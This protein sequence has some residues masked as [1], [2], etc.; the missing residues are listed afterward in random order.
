LNPLRFLCRRIAALALAALTG[1]AGSAAAQDIE[2][3]AYS[4]API[5]Y[6]FLVAGYAYTR[7]GIAFNPS[8][9]L[10]NPDLHTSNAVLG[11][12]RVIELG[13]QSAKFDFNVPYTALSGTADYRG[14][15]VSR[16]I[17]GF[18]NPAFRLSANLYGAP[19]LSPQEFAGWQQDVIVGASLRVSPPWSQYDETRL[20]NVGTNRWTFKPELGVSKAAGPW[21]LELAG[22]AMFFTDNKDFF[23]GNSLSQKPLYSMQ[24]HLIYGFRNGMWASIDGTYFAGGRTT[25][26]GT[27]NTDLQQNWRAGAT[28]A[29]PLD[30]ATSLKFY[31]SSGL[32]ARTGNS[33]D[34]LGVALQYRWLDWQ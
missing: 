5:G 15:Q 2:P 9:P 16:E 20:V 18:G 10:T 19:A 26:N 31:A 12:A 23:G 21:T 13:G 28:F 11:Y 29:V 22:A 8:L 7:G 30:R 24:A 1:V 27:L 25:L 3:R 34:L 32:S 4:N 33:Y 17:H 6:N 14:E